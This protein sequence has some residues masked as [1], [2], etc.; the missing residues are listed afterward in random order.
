MSSRDA[1]LH[2]TASSHVDSASSANDSGVTLACTTENKRIRRATSHTQREG[3]IAAASVRRPLY[4]V[5][6]PAFQW[7][8][9]ARRTPTR[10]TR[11]RRNSID[12][13]V[14][15]LGR[16]RFPAQ[17]RRWSPPRCHMPASHFTQTD[18][19]AS[20]VRGWCQTLS[21]RILQ[22]WRRYATWWNAVQAPR[23]TACR[24]C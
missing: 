11:V 7:C 12:V 16:R 15:R 4:S 8:R 6:P 14:E 21:T 23:Q 13:A 17:Q 1:M 2:V 19:R 20:T 10:M 9:A 22:R 3:N 5:Q 18:Q 24:V